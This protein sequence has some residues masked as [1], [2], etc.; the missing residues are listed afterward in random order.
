MVLALECL[1]CLHGA[2]PGLPSTLDLNNLMMPTLPLISLFPCMSGGSPLAVPYLDASR[3]IT[4]SILLSSHM[5]ELA[6][7]LQW[8]L[9]ELNRS[10][11]NSEVYY[12]HCCWGAALQ[13]LLCMGVSTL[14]FVAGFIT[15]WLH[16]C[17]SYLSFWCH[18]FGYIVYSNCS[19][20]NF[21]LHFVIATRN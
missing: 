21:E 14:E 20:K 15:S 6:A 8:I 2:A 12:M 16:V 5:P 11:R 19:W 18:L 7:K 17:C 9:M 4:G 10:V 3:H 1:F 13:V